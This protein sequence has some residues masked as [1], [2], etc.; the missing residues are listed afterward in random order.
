MGGGAWQA[1]V[2]GV[3]RVVYDFAA[4]PTTTRCLILLSISLQKV[5]VY[6]VVNPFRVSLHGSIIGHLGF[7]SDVELE[8]LCHLT[9][10]VLGT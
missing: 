8:S 10:F 5:C 4:K 2:H 1:V 3:T 9:G 7:L 6:L